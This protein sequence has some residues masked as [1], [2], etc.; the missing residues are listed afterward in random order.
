[1]ST[2]EDT[3]AVFSDA[4][5]GFSSGSRQRKR[6]RSVT[7]VVSAYEKRQRKVKTPTKSPRGK[8]PGGDSLSKELLT[9]IKDVIEKSVQSAL[10]PFTDEWTKTLES[11]QKKIEILESDLFEKAEKIYTLETRLAE[12][13]QQVTRL[14][15][16]IEAMERHD[17][18][19]NLILY[20]KQLGSAR[21]GEDVRGEA[22]ALLSSKFPHLPIS[23]QVFSAAHRLPGDNLIICAF[24]DRDL[25]NR[26]YRDRLGLRDR[27]DAPE[28]RL[29]I[30]ESLTEKNR[31]IFK[32][33]LAM[34]NKKLVWSVFT[35]NG[36]PAFKTNQ[37]S[38]PTRVT[39]LDEVRSLSQRLSEQQRLGPSP[40]PRPSPWARSG[41]GG[42]APAR[43]RPR[44]PEVTAAPAGR[45]RRA[46]SGRGDRRSGE[47]ASAD[48]HDVNHRSSG[49]VE[50]ATSTEAHDDARA[51][52]PAQPPAGGVRN[53]AAPADVSVPGSTISDDS[54][55][56]TGQREA[57]GDG[58]SGKGGARPKVADVV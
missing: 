54:K 3:D 41:R 10:R 57:R 44:S 7:E 25:R 42:T 11:Q 52:R 40:P 28:Q 5:A 34:K 12:T 50:I 23:A 14:T 47:R 29:F 8:N 30:S 51:M 18:G 43:G 33:L 45:G 31:A 16:Q 48:R 46:G 17:R 49:G 55:S 39:S 13:S 21:V 58:D 20:S 56:S 19:S 26:I 15:D 53:D 38:S 32:E 36:I 22:T 4:E 24:W 37:Q 6:E 1:M 2:A 35:N 9:L 27:R